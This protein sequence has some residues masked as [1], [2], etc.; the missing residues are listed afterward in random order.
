MN[1]KKASS[2]F[3]IT[4]L[5][6]AIVV[7]YGYQHRLEQRQVESHRQMTSDGG[8]NVDKEQPEL[9]LNV[10]KNKQHG[11]TANSR[12]ARLKVEQV[13]NNQDKKV[14]SEIIANNPQKPAD[15]ASTNQANH[16]GHEH[17]QPRRHPE[18]NSIIPP[19]EP[20]KPLPNEQG[21]G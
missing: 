5:G 10:D 7:S 6:I 11:D 4:G 8:K 21:K 20:K 19:G 18:D 2:K 14:Q 9:L 12:L 15:H 3:I 13:V 17:Q 16:H 1:I